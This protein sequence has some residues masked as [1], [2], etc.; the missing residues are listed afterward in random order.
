MER[1][2]L[3]RD[4]RARP[5]GERFC[6]SMEKS[7]AAGRELVEAHFE[8]R[9]SRDRWLQDRGVEATASARRERRR[10][11][12]EERHETRRVQP[13]G[14]APAPILD[15][16]EVPQAIAH[17]REVPVPQVRDDELRERALRERQR[18]DAHG[19]RQDVK[20]V[21]RA[22]RERDRAHLR[23]RI[24]LGDRAAEVALEGF[25]KTRGERESARQNEPRPRAGVEQRRERIGIADDDGRIL[26]RDPLERA[27]LAHVVLP[28]EGPVEER[29]P[30]AVARRV[31]DRAEERRSVCERPRRARDAVIRETEVEERP[32]PEEPQPVAPEAERLSGRARGRAALV[33][34][35]HPSRR[36]P[37]A[38]RIAGR[39]RLC[40]RERRDRA[41]RLVRP[42]EVRAHEAGRPHPR[43]PE[44][45]AVVGVEEQRS[46]IAIDGA[47]AQGEEVAARARQRACVARE[48]M[49]PAAPRSRGERVR[50]RR[51]G[52][53]R[54]IE[55]VLTVRDG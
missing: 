25:A 10:R 41:K 15:P 32:P 49:N 1:L 42:R 11:P 54:A 26:A 14:A 52:A 47:L 17:E 19:R 39:L 18:L 20:P 34:R 38:Q 45:N 24:I 3:V 48:L 7:V 22:T 36:D 6:G 29:Q 33:V 16:A 28:E 27:R 30:R 21:P 35:S 4:R 40:A 51:S 50:E 2:E 12:A 53:H 44:G 31:A 23:R 13:A 46:E 37:V 5:L 9:K 8:H 43:L 55:R